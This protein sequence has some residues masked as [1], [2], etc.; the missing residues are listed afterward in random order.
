MVIFKKAQ[1]DL[2]R[3]SRHVLVMCI[4]DFN[5]KLYQRKELQASDKF[6]AR[7]HGTL[8]GEDLLGGAWM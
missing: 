3:R 8:C 1:F 2:C 7:S 4:L 6:S 5:Q